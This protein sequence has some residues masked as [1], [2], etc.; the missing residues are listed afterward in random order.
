MSQSVLVFISHASEDKEE[1]IEPIVRDL[2][3]CFIN[4]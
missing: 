3:D 4:V 1:Y 2:E